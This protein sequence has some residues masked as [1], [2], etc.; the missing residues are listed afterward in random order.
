MN[1]QE[2]VIDE[3][4]L[5]KVT[6]W[7]MNLQEAFYVPLCILTEDP[8]KFI[9]ACKLA[10]ETFCFEITFTHDYKQVKRD[11]TWKHK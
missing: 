9:K 8:E 4:Y 3:A 7:L 5:Y 2:I 11:R 1:N 10:S 6:D